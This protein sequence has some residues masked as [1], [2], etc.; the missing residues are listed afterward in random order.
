[1]LAVIGTVLA[2]LQPST[3][4]SATAA[5]P[6]AEAVFENRVATFNVCNP[7]R[8][9]LL[10]TQHV[11]QIRNEIITYQPQV[12]ALQEICVGEAQLLRDLLEIRGYDYNLALGS[13]TNRPARCF[14]YGQAYGNALLSAAPLTNQVNHL[15]A[16]GGSEPRG[17][18][19][20]DTTV[21]G[22]PVRVFAT[23]LAQAGQ[24]DVRRQQ[25]LELLQDVLAHPQTIVMG[26][27]NAEPTASEL[28][29][30]WTSFRDADP[31]CGPTQNQ[32]PCK[33]TANAAPN[34]KKFDYVFLLRSGA[35]TT[36]NNGVHPNY[37]DHDLVH[38]DLL[39]G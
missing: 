12:I 17:Y 13:V 16:V 7:C 3:P 39:T 5:A 23:H 32:P 20:A 37:S 11:F 25:V 19:A 8:N 31:A 24:A 33:P 35:F 26:D 21:A 34:R 9:P 2:L 22:I 4:A 36:P 30:V 29:P 1:M 14:P 28:V 38:A 10:P 15:Y 6:Q 18:L 27:F